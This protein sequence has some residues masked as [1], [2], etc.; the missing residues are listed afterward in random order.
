MGLRHCLVFS[1]GCRFFLPVEPHGLN[2]ENSKRFRPKSSICEACAT[3]GAVDLVRVP[4]PGWP[5]SV[6]I[7]LTRRIHLEDSQVGARLCLASLAVWPQSNCLELLIVGGR[8]R[9]EWDMRVGQREGKPDGS[10][11]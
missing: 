3:G 4:L 11:Q 10:H 8:F 7:K 5:A 1:S 2:I 6:L 9:Q